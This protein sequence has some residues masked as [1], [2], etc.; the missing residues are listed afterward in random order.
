[1]TSLHQQDYLTDKIPK[2]KIKKQVNIK[3]K[4]KLNCPNDKH[5]KL[6]GKN[7]NDDE[8]VKDKISSTKEFTIS[9]E[10]NLDELKKII[11]NN[12]IACE[13][14]AVMLASDN[15]HG[16]LIDDKKVPSDNDPSFSSTDTSTSPDQY[17][18]ICRTYQTKLNNFEKDIVLRDQLIEELTSSLD[19]AMK[20]K[21]FFKQQLHKILNTTFPSSPS[22]TKNYPQEAQKKINNLQKLLIYNFSLIKKLED[23]KIKQKNSINEYKKIINTSNENIRLM[24]NKLNL[25]ILETLIMEKVCKK[26]VDKITHDLNLFKKKYQ[27]DRDEQNKN[28]EKKHFDELKKLKDKY[29][30]KISDIKTGYDEKLQEKSQVNKNLCDQIKT[31][32]ENMTTVE[33][34]DKVLMKSLTD[35]QKSVC[36]IEEKQENLIEQVDSYRKCII[37]LSDKISKKDEDIKKIHT[38]NLMIIQEYDKKIDNIKSIENIN[39]N[40]ENN[41]DKLKNQVNYYEKEIKNIKKKHCNDISKLKLDYDLIFLLIILIFYF[42]KP[43]M[44]L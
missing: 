15:L 44:Y 23:E 12:G 17:M 28:I 8:I 27:D 26:Q 22:S 1:M 16:K 10:V 11:N 19:Q 30:K 35:Y 37:Y 4:E 34:V 24:K 42:I 43:F 39:K 21:K 3:I 31:M 29:H 2:E 14:L 36:K 9:Q 7:D 13:C 40:L 32:M 5:E 25:N 6:K 18:T 38:D 33:E 41:I 20:T